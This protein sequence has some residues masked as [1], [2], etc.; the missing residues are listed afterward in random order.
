MS[1]RGL[2]SDRTPS[3]FISAG[4]EADLY[5][6]GILSNLHEIRTCTIMTRAATDAMAGIHDRMPVILNSEERDAWLGGSE[7]LRLRAGAALKCWPDWQFGLL[8]VG[9]E[10]IEAAK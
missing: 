10:L 5:F 4:N 7:D 6:A 9:P 1:G 2:K 8:D 3:I